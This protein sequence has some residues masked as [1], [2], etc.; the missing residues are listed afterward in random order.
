MNC[1]CYTIK[2]ESTYYV[3]IGLLLWIKKLLL[4]WTFRSAQLATF[5][6]SSTN[7]LSIQTGFIFDKKQ[8]WFEQ[9]REV[10]SGQWLLPG[11]WA[12][13]PGVGSC[14]S[15]LWERQGRVSQEV[16]TP[17]PQPGNRTCQRAVTCMVLGVGLEL[18]WCKINLW[19]TT[20]KICIVLQG[21]CF[22]DLQN[23]HHIICFCVILPH[24][25]L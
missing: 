4:N 2:F 21:F 19:C 17:P 25:L 9:C 20:H 14:R 22:R 23:L 3:H 13:L 11:D 16:P 6:L 12:W 15:S 7:S 10:T 24:H 8:T 18:M 5:R 1:L